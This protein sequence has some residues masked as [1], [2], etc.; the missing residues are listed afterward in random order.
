MKKEYLDL[1]KIYKKKQP[2]LENPFN[3]KLYQSNDYL[4]KNLTN[5][6]KVTKS[7]FKKMTNKRYMYQIYFEIFLK[8]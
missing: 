2:D 5:F 1:D 4:E 8:N 6:Q 7:K 3:L